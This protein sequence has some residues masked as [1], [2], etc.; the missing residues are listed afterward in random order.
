[1]AEAQ[2]QG[3]YE[4]QKDAAASTTKEASGW[5]IGLIAFAAIMMLLVGSF[6]FIQGLAAVLNSDFYVIRPGYDLSIDTT[7]W[8]YAHIVGG[9]I[10][11]IAGACLFTGAVWARAV[12]VIAAAISAIG[13]FYSIPYYPVWSILLIVIDFAIVWALVA[14]GRDIALEPV[15]SK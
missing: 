6:H 7:A 13:S 15:D 1:M 2:Y 10:L 3:P 12:G 8:G 11:C 4:N 9:V 5:A 14:H